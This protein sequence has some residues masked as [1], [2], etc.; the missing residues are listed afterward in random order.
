MK[1]LGDVVHRVFSL[2]VAGVE[3]GS[4]C[5]GAGQ[6]LVGRLEVEGDAAAVPRGRAG[7]IQG[8]LAAEMEWTVTRS[9][10]C[11]EGHL[12]LNGS[13]TERMSRARS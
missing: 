4:P 8:M 6:G 11:L 13:W 5:A 1:A 10:E 7:V 12:T 2:S 3:H 9:V